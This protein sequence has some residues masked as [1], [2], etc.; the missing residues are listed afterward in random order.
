MKN[1]A[2]TSKHRE[3]A[4]NAPV[5]GAG[6]TAPCTSPE[7]AL[8]TALVGRAKRS[9]AL[10]RGRIKKAKLAGSRPP[11]VAGRLIQSFLDTRKVAG[12]PEARALE[13]ELSKAIP[14]NAEFGPFR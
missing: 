5:T 2:P 9:Q 7:T 1:D 14:A 3:T 10:S 8:L 12:S 13:A 6:S 4:K 11:R